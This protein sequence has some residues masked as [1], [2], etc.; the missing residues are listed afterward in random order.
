MPRAATKKAAAS[1]D[2]DP[3]DEGGGQTAMNVENDLFSTLDEERDFYKILYYGK[4][5]AI[6][7]TCGS[8]MANAG[9]ILVINVEGGLKKKALQGRGVNTANIVIY[10]KPGQTPTRAGIVKA[11]NRVAA[12]LMQ[13]PNSW[14]GIFLDSATE[15]T[16]QVLGAVQ[17]RRVRRLKDQDKPHDPDFVDIADYGTMSKIVRDILRLLRDIPCHVVIS[18]LERRDVD[19]DTGKPQY[20]PA[21]SPALATD[22]MGYVDMVLMNKAPDEDGP[23]R[24]LCRANSRYRAKDRFDVLPRV[25]AEPTFDRVAGY[26]EG[27]LTEETDEI[28]K[29][30]PSKAIKSQDKADE[31]DLADLDDEDDEDD[32]D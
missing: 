23:A 16:Q 15:I 11:I 5:G 6:K 22:I 13:D 25:L 24:A 27:T 14:Y 28:Q 21:I 7:T 20:G 12:D 10:P 9:K 31:D 3:Q 18:A 29:S 19:K 26:I 17:V 32:E 2:A 30:L 4:E 8:T 1:Q